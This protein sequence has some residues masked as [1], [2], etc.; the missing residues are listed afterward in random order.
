MWKRNCIGIVILFYLGHLNA[1]I[2][3]VNP[4]FEDQPGDATTPQGWFVCENYTTPD[5]LPGY[6][7]VNNEPVDGDTFMGI[8]TRQD[9]SFESIGQKMSQSM[10]KDY[11]YSFDIDLAHSK[12]YAGFNKPIKLRIWLGTSKSG[13]DQLIFE[14]KF[15][16]HA[17]WRTYT[18]D[19]TTKGTYRYI[20]IEAFYEEGDFSHKGNLLL[21]NMTVITRCNKA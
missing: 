8:I 6:W 20:R 5:I 11:C 19:F 21:D 16:D 9:G 1:Q 15:I 14:S 18:I 4:S 7:G 13:R 12:T 3:L 2:T 17:E 10:A